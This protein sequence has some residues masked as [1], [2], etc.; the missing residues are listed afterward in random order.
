[1]VQPKA[2]APDESRFIS[3]MLSARN[4]PKQIKRGLQRLSGHLERRRRIPESEDLRQLTKSLLWDGDPIVRMYAFKVLGLFARAEDAEIVVARLKQEPDFETQTWGMAALIGIAGDRDLARVFRDTGLETSLPLLLAGQL[5]ANPKWV[6]EN[7]K[8]LHVPENSDRITMK[9][10]VLLV[11]YKK[12]PPNLFSPRHDNRVLLGELNK[13]HVDEIAEHSTWALFEHPE[14]GPSDYTIDLHNIPQLPPSVK[15]WAFRLLMTDPEGSGID[16]DALA[17][18]RRD[19][20]LAARE[21]LALGL[22]RF[23]PH[24]ASRVVL[25]W[26][27][28]EREEPVRELLLEHMATRSANP[29]YASTVVEAFHSAAVGGPVRGRL[30]AAAQGTPVYK[31]LQRRVA[32]EAIV[33]AGMSRDLLG[34]DFVMG[35]KVSI[36]GDNNGFAS[37]GKQSAQNMVAGNMIGSANGAVQS[38][39]NERQADKELLQAILAVLRENKGFKDGAADAV[40]DAV[41]EVAK[42]PSPKNKRSLFGALK[43]LVSGADLA[44]ELVEHVDKLADTVTAL[45]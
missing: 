9:W 43:A 34:G 23:N 35:N 25:E 26:F 30:L 36:G 19:N 12:A 33:K 8:P 20:D 7:Y 29:D 17:D 15:K 45:F 4:S 10:A 41:K 3:V 27:E 38:L 13:H 24:G 28:A 22:D 11:A 5:Y 14:Y 16:C 6:T 37:G 42:E 2:I 40:A 18:L 32:V 21:G 31:E 44:A 39:S 1:M